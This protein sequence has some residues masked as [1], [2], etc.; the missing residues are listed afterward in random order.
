MGRSAAV[1]SSPV[2]DGTAHVHAGW[3]AGVIATAGA[4]AC[5]LS[6][7]APLLHGLPL[8]PAE[9]VIH[10]AV[11]AAYI[12]AGAIA[13]ARRPRNAVGALMA[14]VGFLWLLPDLAWI[15]SPLPFTLATTYPQLYQPVLA[16]L[17]LAFPSGRLPGRGERW[18][19][20]YLY[21][22][23]LLN[24]LAV[25]FFADPRADGCE[26]CPR[27]L[28]LVDSSRTL[29]DRVSVVVT[30]ISIVTVV[31]TAAVIVRHWWSATRA[32]Q[33]VMAPVLWVVGPAAGYIV[34]SELTELATFPDGWQRII[35][36]YL[37][38]SLAVLPVGFLVGLLRT[39]LAYAHLGRFATELAGPI[40]PGRVRAVLAKM[41]H[42]PDLELHYWSPS[43]RSYVDLEGNPASPE[44]A[45]G[46]T[47][48]RIDGESGPLARLIVDRAV[49]EEPGLVTAAGAMARLALE[50]ERLQAEV[51]SQLVDLRSTSAR[52]VEAGQ[53]ARRRLERDLHDGAQQRLLALSMTLGQVRDRLGSD[54]E[55]ELRGYL[56]R[57]N[58]D[59]QEAI[60]ELRELARG[61]HP[62]LLSQEGLA[63]A[64]QAL[65]ERATLPVVVSAPTTRFGERI[66]STVYFLVSEAVT[67]AARYS[68]AGRVQVNVWQA[69][70]EVTVEVADDGVGGADGYLVG[71]GLQGMRDRV[72]ALGGHM[73]VT[74][75]RGGGTRIEARLP[76][77]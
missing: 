12:G 76:C 3:L 5:A 59:L 46:R 69:G 7:A 50:N 30:V 48:T 20:V 67:N 45:D 22:F 57:A 68:R 8:H 14:V 49:L 19:M 73:R 53:E 64:L 61:I 25:A 75:P 29:E 34:V 42:D 23:A 44:P 32:S 2:P 41:L 39:R 15:R 77:E 38:L 36:D 54:P 74:S 1:P 16:H 47:V 13:L 28:F 24:N 27:N 6:L 72:T 18:L 60:A 4:L 35:R 10:A 55:P 66:E 33:Y 37:P 43:T 63:S 51:R 71:T 21:V 40:I 11:S 52:L 31:A 17:A 9:Q 70:D 62:V 26:R 58:A 65:A 56:E